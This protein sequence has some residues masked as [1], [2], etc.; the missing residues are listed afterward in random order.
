MLSES[1]DAL[2]N[3]LKKMPGIGEKTATRLALFLIEMPKEEAR[4]IGETL[5]T[6]VETFKNCPVC[7]ILT[8]QTPCSFCCDEMRDKNQLCVVENTQDVFL[9][10]KTHEYKGQYFV[11]GKLLSPMDGIG[12]NEINFPLLLKYL[13]ENPVDELILALSP[14]VEGETTINYLVQQIHTEVKNITRLSTG[15]PFG[16]DMEYA[17]SKTLT[18]ALQRRYTIED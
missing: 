7:N 10:E 6:A 4:E 16:G 8:D 14:S 5:I 18:T 15:L 9:V 11:L 3:G 13:A 2:V 12:P 17:T 1:F